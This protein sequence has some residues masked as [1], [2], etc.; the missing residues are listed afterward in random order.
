[1]RHLGEVWNGVEQ[2]TDHSLGPCRNLASQGR[3]CRNRASRSSQAQRR[4]TPGGR[5]AKSDGLIRAVAADERGHCSQD[6][7]NRTKRAFPGKHNVSNGK[8]NPEYLLEVLRLRHPAETGFE[9]HLSGRLASRRVVRVARVAHVRRI[10]LTCTRLMLL[11]PEDVPLVD[12][13]LDLVASVAHLCELAGLISHAPCPARHG[14]AALVVAPKWRP[15]PEVAFA[16]TGHG[17][18]LARP[19]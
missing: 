15:R 3:I 8:S 19:A 4:Q 1:M 18:H 2:N 7:M 14:L 16:K 12:R 6:L 10:T 13:L 9:H 5:S 17:D 11:L